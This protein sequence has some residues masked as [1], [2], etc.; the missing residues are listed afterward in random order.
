MAFSPSTASTGRSTGG[1]ASPP[2]GAPSASHGRS[3]SCAAATSPPPD[4]M[5]IP[6]RRLVLISA[7][8]VVVAGVAVGALAS[9]SKSSI[10][11]ARLERSLP[12][13]FSNLYV[14]QA[15]LLGHKGVTV[16]SLHPKAQ[17]DKGGAGV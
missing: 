6:P 9:V 11:R 15:R 16:R 7:A 10:T 2:A 17:C 8:I 3:S 5:T 13:T 12:A 1:S 4:P 14:Q